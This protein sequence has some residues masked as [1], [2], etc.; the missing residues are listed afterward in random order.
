MSGFGDPRFRGGGVACR[1]ASQDDRVRDAQIARRL[2]VDRRK[3]RGPRPEPESASRPRRS[4]GAQNCGEPAAHRDEQGATPAAPAAPWRERNWLVASGPEN[5]KRK[6]VGE[7]EAALEYLVR[8]PPRRADRGHAGLS[9]MH[10]TQALETADGLSSR[11][12]ALDAENPFP[13]KTRHPMSTR[14]MRR[15]ALLD[16]ERPHSIFAASSRQVFCLKRI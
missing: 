8:R 10:G 9:L 5:T 2:V 12:K 4:R 7:D 11:A 16:W 14:P 1:L 13:Y 15:E 6:R 3:C